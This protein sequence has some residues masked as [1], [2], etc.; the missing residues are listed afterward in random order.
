MQNGIGEKEK[1]MKVYLLW[2]K[3]LGEPEENIL[4]AIY[5]EKAKA[6]IAAKVKEETHDNLTRQFIHFQVTEEVIK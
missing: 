3:V 2:E 5:Q 4:V 1:E 6:E